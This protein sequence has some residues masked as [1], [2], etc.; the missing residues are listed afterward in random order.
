MIRSVIRKRRMAERKA[1]LANRDFTVIAKDCTGA[2]LLHDLG[3]RFDTP[4]VNL[5]FTA[6]DYVK[7]CSRLEHYIAADLVEDTT[8]TEPFPVGLLDDV[9]VYF[10]H[11][12]TFEAAKQKWQ[13]RST[14]IHWDNL[15]FLMTDGC[16]SSEALVREFDALPSK[17]KVLLTCR[18]YGDV[19]CAVKMDIPGREGKDLGAPELFRY[20]GLFVA[21]KA[22]DNWDYISFLNGK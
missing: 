5:F 8:V 13:Q 17:H 7:F 12:K 16:G 4:T 3:L 18:N 15:F 20:K 11:Y 9:R 1:A 21:D 10:R 22:I 14:R 19:K 6:G 2:M